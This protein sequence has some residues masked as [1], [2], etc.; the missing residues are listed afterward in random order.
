MIEAGIDHVVVVLGPEKEDVRAALGD[1][2]ALGLTLS[3]LVLEDSGSIPETIDAARSLCRDRVVAFGF[4]DVAYEPPHVF[5]EIFERWL[6]GE[7][8]IVLG[9]FPT[10]TPQ[11][12]DMVDVDQDGSVRAIEIKPEATELRWT[13]L[14]AVWGPRFTEYLSR[15]RPRLEEQLDREVYPG[16]LFNEALED[17]MTI[18]CVTFEDGRHLDIGTRDDLERATQPGG[19]GK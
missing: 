15:T 6:H 13:W 17:G 2:Q 3:Y 18:E 9:A 4:P 14:A 8:D 12:A 10:D 5:K 16:D 1:G 19:G 7:M 11:K